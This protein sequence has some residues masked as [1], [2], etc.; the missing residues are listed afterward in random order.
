LFSAVISEHFSKNCTIISVVAAKIWYLKKWAV[1]IG[2]PC[3]YGTYN[4]CIGGRDTAL[5]TGQNC[6]TMSYVTWWQIWLQKIWCQ[7]D[8]S[9]CSCINP[10]KHFH[11]SLSMLPVWLCKRKLKSS[12]QLH[13]DVWSLQRVN[14]APSSQLHQSR[15]QLSYTSSPFDR[16]IQVDVLSSECFFCRSELPVS[17]EKTWVGWTRTGHHEWRL[18]SPLSNDAALQLWSPATVHVHSTQYTVHLMQYRQY[19]TRH[20]TLDTLHR[21]QRHI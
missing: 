4:T 5:I 8:V 21:A 6:S 13:G 2:P 17:V 16:L 7:T 20:S 3:T 10:A 9:G 11:A 18:T 1:F 12:M 19:I 15:S 14:Y